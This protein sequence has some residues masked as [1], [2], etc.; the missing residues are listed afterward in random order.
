MASRRGRGEGSITKR[1]D[2][3]WMARVDLGWQGGKRRRQTLYGRTRV[4]VQGRLRDALHRADRGEAPVPMQE[5]VGAFLARWLEGRRG[6]I[7]PRTHESYAQ[8]V[9][10]RIVPDL[11][12]IRLAK[13]TPLDVSTWLSRLQEAGVGG[14]TVQYARV[15]LRAALNQALKWELVT[16]NVAAMTE[17]PQHRRREIEPLTPDQAKA[18]LAA[19]AGHRL[20]ALFTVAVG[21]GLRRGEALGLSWDSVDLDAGVL[22]VFRTLERA[23]SEPRF[24][25]PKTARGRRTIT[26]PNIVASALRGHRSRQLEERLAAGPRW[27]DFGLVFTTP[28]GTPLDGRNVTRRFKTILRRAGLPDIRYHDLRHTAATLLLAQGVDPRT[29]M[30]TL[31]HSEIGMTLNTYAHVVPALQR[32]AAAKMDA[33]LSR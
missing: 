31:G 20:E 11:G 28:T 29:I 18:L 7:R 22:S 5:T 21:I 14:R 19:V 13:L 23:G 8:L 24:G 26:L 9:R 32:E 17:P 25:E 30:E 6:R 10:T 27:Q 4:E 2:G 12:R 3:R 16:R 33:L 1:S 15:V